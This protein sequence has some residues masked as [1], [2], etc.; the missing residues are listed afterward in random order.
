MQIDIPYSSVRHEMDLSFRIALTVLSLTIHPILQYRAGDWPIMAYRPIVVCTRSNTTSIRGIHKRGPISQGI[1]MVDGFETNQ[2]EV[3][4]K[5]DLELS[6][7][8]VAK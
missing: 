6:T 2:L 7:K 4:H 5:F 3:D 8:S 1:T